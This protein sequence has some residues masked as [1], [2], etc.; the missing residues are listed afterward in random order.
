M[1]LN[2]TPVAPPVISETLVIKPTNQNDITKSNGNKQIL[3]EIP[4]YVRYF[5]PSQSFFQSNVTMT[6]RGNPIPSSSAG[7]HSFWRRITCRDGRTNANILDEIDYYNTYASQLYTTMKTD[8]INN[9]RLMFQGLQPND[10]YTD[11]LYWQLLDGKKTWAGTPDCA[12]KVSSGINNIE[13][14]PKPVQI[15]TA[16]QTELLSTNDFVPVNVLGGLNMELQIEDY[17]RALEFT[18]GELGV[19][20]GNGVCP[21]KNDLTNG[22]DCCLIPDAGDNFVD[23]N[24]YQLR[25]GSATGLVCGYVKVNTTNGAVD[26][27][28][29][30]VDWYSTSNVAVCPPTSATGNLIIVSPSGVAGDNA[31]VT[32]RP[33]ILPYGNLRMGSK[34]APYYV[35]IATGTPVECL[36]A[37]ATTNLN[38]WGSGTLRDPFRTINPITNATAG[39][40]AQ[41]QAPSNNLPFSVGDLLFVAK[42][43]QTDQKELGLITGFSLSDNTNTVSGT[44]T[45]RVYFSPNAPIIPTLGNNVAVPTGTGSTGVGSTFAYNF[46]TNGYELFVKEFHRLDGVPSQTHIEAPT[47]SPTAIIDSLK[48]IDFVISDLEY[49]VKRVM[50]DSSID[51]NDMSLSTGTGYKFDLNSTATTLVNVTNVLGPTNQTITLPNIRRGLSILSIPLNQNDQFSISKKSLVG[52]PRGAIVDSATALQQGMSNYQYNLG[53]LIGR[54]PYRPVDVRKYSF[55]NPLIQTGAVTE[56]IKANESFGFATSC[57]QALG[58][59]FA[60]GR[61]LARPGQFFDITQAGNIELLANFEN[62]SSGNKLFV[63]FVRHLRRVNVSRM[64]LIIEN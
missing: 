32:I 15:S 61:A 39:L 4:D 1:D 7:F 35:D 25:V 45:C 23:G 52:D 6:G 37:V 21:A 30:S 26:K 16:L 11:N 56:L 28:I 62:V 38:S 42:S 27:T 53:T 34:D 9:D 20:V 36:G 43:D 29:G 60:L 13:S 44:N 50:M 63:H 14:F 64:G 5:L 59:N 46:A 49:H 33:N 10:S 12:G 51:N 54:Q 57:L 24:L 55:K 40:S 22:V 41:N 31:T 18:T 19:N 8:Q 3:I 2:D 17:R 47:Y 48:K 58:M